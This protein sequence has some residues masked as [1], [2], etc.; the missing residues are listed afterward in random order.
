MTYRHY[1]AIVDFGIYTGPTEYDAYS[2]FGESLFQSDMVFEDTLN[3]LK[4][5]DEGECP[6]DSDGCKVCDP[7]GYCD[8]EI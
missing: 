7:Y 6:G 3:N 2:R 8:E 1:R 5:I 4:L